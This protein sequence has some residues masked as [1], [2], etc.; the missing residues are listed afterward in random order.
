MKNVFMAK[1]HLSNPNRFC[2]MFLMSLIMACGHKKECMQE[3]EPE[4]HNR[5][6]STNLSY[7][8]IGFDSL[9]LW[10]ANPGFVADSNYSLN[11]RFD[12]SDWYF[13]GKEYS[14]EMEG[15]CSEIP[16]SLNTDTIP[17]ENYRIRVI[18]NHGKVFGILFSITKGKSTT[19]TFYF[20]EIL[21]SSYVYT[22][23]NVYNADI[24]YHSTVEMNGDLKTEIRFIGEGLSFEFSALSRWDRIAEV[25]CGGLFD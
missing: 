6:I 23:R 19:T 14:S 21:D 2:L 5:L 9:L 11:Y 24:S 16:D 15:V 12:E 4:C 13:I 3:I 18:P 1:N 25:E 17:V 10:H 7:L 22:S 20:Q 8:E